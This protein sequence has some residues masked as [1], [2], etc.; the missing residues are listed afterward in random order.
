MNY[1]NIPDDAVNLVAQHINERTNKPYSIPIIGNPNNSESPQIFEITPFDEIDKLDKNIFAIDGSYNSQQ[2][3]NGVSIGIYN[4]GYI[5]YKLGKQ[6]RM[7][8]GSDPIILGK[9]YYP[10]NILITK[11]EHLSAIYDELLVLKPIKDLL[12][13]FHDTTENIFSYGKE[14]VCSSLST[15]LS[16]AQ[17]ILEWALVYEVVNR[18]EIGKDDFILRDG[19]LRSVN[20]QQTCLVKLG[21]LLHEKGIIIVGIT[22]HSTIKMELSYTLKQIDNYLQDQLKPKYPFTQKD[23]RRQKLCCWFE[24]PDDVLLASYSG[25]MYTKKDIKGGRGFGLFTVARLDYVEKLQNYDWFVADVN[26]FDAIPGIENNKKERDMKKL[27]EIFKEL[28]T[29][30]QEHYIL[31]YPYPLVEVH[32]FVSLKKNFKEEIIKRVKFALYKEQRMDNIEIENLFLD[33]HDKF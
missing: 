31:G 32:N 5:C 12:S 6:I 26:I 25:T 24:I 3:Y 20:I 21:K 9:A 22:K 15:V 1:E 29:L 23:P 4:A 17:E 8:E 14:T 7:N 18:S 28:T 27:A 16:F 2:F 33:I 19:P 11:D 10:Q 13:F 30:T